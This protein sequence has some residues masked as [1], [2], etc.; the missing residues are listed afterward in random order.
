MPASGVMPVSPSSRFMPPVVFLR[1][2][3]SSSARRY[4]RSCARLRSSSS[5]SFAARSAYHSGSWVFTYGESTDA[6]VGLSSS[7]RPTMEIRPRLWSFSR[8]SFVQTIGFWLSVPAV[9]PIG[10]TQR[11]GRRNDCQTNRDAQVPN[12]VGRRYFFE[13]PGGKC[14]NILSAPLSRFL[15]FLSELLESVS[16]DVPLQISCL[17]LASNRST[18]NVPTL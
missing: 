16:L 6:D 10:R 4:S 15:M 9:R 1:L 8:S 2:S 12:H 7:I 18:T 11:N 17:V 13:E 14:L 5:R 3:A